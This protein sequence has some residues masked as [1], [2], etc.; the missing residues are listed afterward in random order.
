M[1]L[2][3]DKK[4]DILLKEVPNLNCWK[5]AQEWIQ[6]GQNLVA[7]LTSKAIL[8]EEILSIDWSDINQ[9][10]EFPF[11]LYHSEKWR[12]FVLATFL[13]DLVSYTIPVDQVNFERL[14]F[15]MHLF[16]QGFRT[17][18]I[19]LQNNL[20]WPVGYT[21]WYP[22]LENAY[23]LF[24]RSPEKLKDRMVIPNTHASDQPPYLYLFNYSVA[25]ALK[26]SRLSKNLIKQYVHEIGNQKARGLACITVSEDGKRL[27]D[28]LGMCCTGHL[29]LDGSIEDVYTTSTI[30]P[31]RKPVH[32]EVD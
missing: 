26:K 25:P 32:L 8:E 20:W 19:K 12:Q 7:Q 14:A 28:R 4:H 11:G 27:A 10:R 13:A 21:G 31:N 16:P 5:E 24:E 17:W 2:M 22:M 9:Q 29:I 18:W 15:V 3:P 23:A 30:H 1:K 6:E